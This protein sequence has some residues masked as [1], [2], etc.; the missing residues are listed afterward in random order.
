MSTRRASP[1]GW[2][3]RE[4]GACRRCGSVVPKGRYTFCSE[5]C[6]H[7]WRLRTD[8]GYL[9]EQVFLRDGGVCGLCGID[10]EQLRKEKRKL[11]Y[12]SRKQ[13]ERDWG[14]RRHFWDADHILPVAEGGGECDL[15]NLRTLCL[16]C[17]RAVTAE[18]RKRLTASRNKTP[19]GPLAASGKAEAL[20]PGKKA[21]K[22]R[23]TKNEGMHG[24]HQQAAQG[25]KSAGQTEGQFGR[26]MKGRRG[27]FGGAGDAPLI[28]K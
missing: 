10:T 26:D 8:P 13:F 24:I 14:G 17:H 18:L 28:K 12:L 1:G 19:L 7:E 20:M 4:R 27:Q 2:V 6:V 9:R 5:A 3:K 22:S 15:H 11:D 23:V 25:R 16:K 21:H